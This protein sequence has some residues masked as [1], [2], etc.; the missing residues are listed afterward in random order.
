MAVQPTPEPSTIAILLAGIACSAGAA[1]R[2]RRNSKSHA[3]PQP[4]ADTV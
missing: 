3:F 2:I 1:G 4:P